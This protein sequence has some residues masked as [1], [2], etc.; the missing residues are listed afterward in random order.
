MVQKLMSELNIKRQRRNNRA[1]EREEKLRPIAR[2]VHPQQKT[3][4]HEPRMLITKPSSKLAAQHVTTKHF[5]IDAHASG[6]AQHAVE[7]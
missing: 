1:H 2:A 7:Y 6:R 4:A 3:K 5:A